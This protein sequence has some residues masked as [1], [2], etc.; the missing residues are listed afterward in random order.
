MTN[1]FNVF[2]VMQIFNM[3]NVRKVNDEK[4][5]FDGILNNPY[6]IIIWIIIVGGQVIIIELT[7]ETFKVSKYGLHIYHWIIAVILGLCTWVIRFFL[8]FVPITWCP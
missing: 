3:I 8:T 7:G 2:V 6:Y 4:N 1:V 5:I